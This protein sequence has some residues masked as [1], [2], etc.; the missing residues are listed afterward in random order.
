MTFTASGY[1][2]DGT[3]LDKDAEV[4]GTVYPGQKGSAVCLIRAGEAA[5]PLAEASRI[6]LTLAT[7]AETGFGLW[8][9]VEISLR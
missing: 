4:L 6:S 5:A 1:V 3:A 7:E 8:E 2:Q 9:Q